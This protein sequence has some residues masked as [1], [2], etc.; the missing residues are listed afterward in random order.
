MFDVERQLNI[1]KLI[2]RRGSVRVSDLSES[3]GVSPNTIRRDLKKLEGDGLLR[4]THGGA[5]L[6]GPSDM[7][8]TLAERLDE[9]LDEKSRIGRKAAELIRDGESIILDAGT[10]TAQIAKHIGGRRGLTVI[11]NAINIA[12]ELASSP[13]IATILTGGILSDITKCTA[14]FHAEQFLSQFH[15]SKAFISAGGVTPE[16]ATNTNTFEVQMKRTMM[17]VAD[18]VILVVAHN[19]IGT[20]SLAPFA[21]IEDIHKIITDDGAPKDVVEAI[22]GKGVEVILC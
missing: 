5:V 18:E 9:F 13:G 6:V 7:G 20:V 15:V 21:S 1:V 11:T 4:R 8:P 22:R 16:G 12:L 19:K 2:R 10:T 17:R 14:G 3:L